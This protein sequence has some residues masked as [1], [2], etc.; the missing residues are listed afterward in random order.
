MSDLT[1]V[2]CLGT[3]QVC[4]VSVAAAEM[5]LRLTV[6]LLLLLQARARHMPVTAAHTREPGGAPI[7]FN[8]RVR[9]RHG[10]AHAVRLLGAAGG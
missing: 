7:L 5:L 2:L 1:C 6:L 10:D 8:R 3:P 4:Y 9:G